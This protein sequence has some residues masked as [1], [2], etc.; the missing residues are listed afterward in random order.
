[1]PTFA[2]F[3]QISKFMNSFSALFK[4][5]LL[6]IHTTNRHKLKSKIILILNSVVFTCVFACFLELIAPLV[7]LEHVL[8]KKLWKNEQTSLVFWSPLFISSCV[9]LKLK[10]VVP[11]VLETGCTPVLLYNKHRVRQLFYMEFFFFES[12]LS[13][14]INVRLTGKFFYCDKIYFRIQQRQV[15]INFSFNMHI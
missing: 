5:V 1:M 6:F 2:N 10:R 15:V 7:S 4:I 12:A 14:M 8:W 11:Q 13:Q 3:T 9:C